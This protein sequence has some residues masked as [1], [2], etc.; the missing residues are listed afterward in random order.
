MQALGYLADTDENYARAKALVDGLEET[1]KTV[2]AAAFLR[3]SGAQGERSEKAYNSP[4]YRNHL[5][6]LENAILELELLRA[7]RTTE[8]LYIEVWRSLQSARKQGVIC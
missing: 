6:L 2:K 5:T 3:A 1:K 8:A 4:E 7:K